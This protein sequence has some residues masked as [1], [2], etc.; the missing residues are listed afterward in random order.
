MLDM[1]LNSEKVGHS[2]KHILFEAI[3]L[4]EKNTGAFNRIC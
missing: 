3:P 2:N 1:L 4:S